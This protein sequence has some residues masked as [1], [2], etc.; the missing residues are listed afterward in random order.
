MRCYL[1]NKTQA[2]SLPSHLDWTW[3]HPSIHNTFR[4]KVSNCHFTVM[5]CWQCTMWVWHAWVKGTGHRHRLP[6]P[7]H[8]N[9]PHSPPKPTEV[10]EIIRL[11]GVCHRNC[12]LLNT[13]INNRLYEMSKPFCISNNIVSN[14]IL[15]N[16]PTFLKSRLWF[17]SAR[18]AYFISPTPNPSKKMSPAHF[19]CTS[20]EKKICKTNT[21][22]Q[23]SQFRFLKIKKYISMPHAQ[24]LKWL[25]ISPNN[26]CNV[27]QS[28]ILL[29]R[30]QTTFHTQN[31]KIVTASVGHYTKFQ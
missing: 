18:F 30:E 3:T 19:Y 9:L 24:T 7:L 8:P 25:S 29:N 15:Q 10:L 12:L 5:F 2:V 22:A 27:F 14:D 26:L 6:P 13:K 4:H 1:R 20:Q 11:M 28:N 31:S 23:I 16:L 17:P 21:S